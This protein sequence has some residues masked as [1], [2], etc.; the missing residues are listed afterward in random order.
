MLSAHGEMHECEELSGFP[1]SLL[2]W[3]HDHLRHL[4]PPSAAAST[5][6]DLREHREAK[7][8]ALSPQPSAKS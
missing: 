4:F 7:L 5:E 8:P 6:S 3:Q 1:Y 2:A